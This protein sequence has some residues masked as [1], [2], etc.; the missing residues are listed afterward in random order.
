MPTDADLLRRYAQ[1]HDEK[2]FAELV[3]RHL[4]VVYAAAL[5][6]IGGR[7]HLAEEISQKVF[8]DLARKA[9]WLQRHPAIIGWLHCSTRYA[10]IDATRAVSLR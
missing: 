2:A 3:A 1:D 4:D 8:A 10:A 6:R 9:T 7:R 5:R